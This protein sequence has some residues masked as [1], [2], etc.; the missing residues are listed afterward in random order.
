MPQLGNVGEFNGIG[1]W[2]SG[3]VWSALAIRDQLTGSQTNK[4]QVVNNLK[5][6]FKLRKNYDQFGWWATAALYAH[7]AYNDIELLNNAIA[8]WESV[9]QFVVSPSDAQQN[10]HP[11][12]N[13]A[14]AGTCDGVTMAGGV[15][16]RPTS[17]DT[18]INSITTG[19]YFTLSAYLAEVTKQSKYT[20]AAILS[21]KWIILHNLND[22]NIVL[23]TVSGSNCQRSPS[24]WIFTY[25]SGKFIE[26]LS[27]LT[28]VTGDKQ[29]ETQMINTLAA[30]VKNTAWQGT[31]GIITEGSDNSTNNDGIGFKA[32]F[33]RGLL[34]AFRRTPENTNLRILIHSYIDVQYNALL[35]LAKTNNFYSA[36]W[37]GPAPTQFTSWGQLAAL[38]VLVSAVEAN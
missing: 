36:N 22:K 38:D 5:L 21:A 11:L 19:L 26:G 27:V 33:I 3:N 2:Q 16:W 24:N 8:T 12:K 17:D 32:V 10:K 4:A 7:K 18:A 13:F 1:Y 6:V 31:D 29:W 14:L 34:E 15:F 23:D 25:N 30:A 9:S 37:K 35:D 20:D 28:D